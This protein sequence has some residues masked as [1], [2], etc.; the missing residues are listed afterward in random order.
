LDPFKPVAR[1]L[2]FYYDLVP[3]Y[4]AAIALL[5]ITVMVVLLPLTLK[6]TRSQLAMQK[7]APEI[8]KLQDK[9][10]NDRQKMNEEVMAV[11]RD[12]KINP[13]GGC[14]PMLLQVPVFIILY[15]VISGMTHHSK[16]VS[17]PKYLS[18][19]SR[20]YEDIAAAHG[21][22]ES[23]GIDLAQRAA[24]HH[25]SFFA[26]IPFILL[27]VV[28]VALQYIQTAQIMR[29]SPQADTPMAQQ[30]RTM[31]KF[32]PLMFGIFAIGIPAGVVVYWVISSIFRI[33][34]QWG[35]YRWDPLL[36]TTV[37]SAQKEAQQFLKVDDAKGRAQKP[38]TKRASSNNKK[39][40]KGR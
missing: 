1:L 35:M 19:S 14:L 40:R 22:M 30:M 2:S 24:S 9:H 38:G 8:K 17:S 21:K 15:R 23:F 27:V 16:G 13:L 4:A 5:T 36:R 32:L 25:S 20:L 34:Q 12:N 18:H 39:K 11:Y 31:Q 33:G 26:A 37:A 7:L 3:N 10:K 6:A 29:R 28:M